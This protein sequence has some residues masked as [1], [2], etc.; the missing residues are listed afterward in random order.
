MVLRCKN[1]KEGEVVI[2]D[3]E[4]YENVIKYNW[5]IIRGKKD[6]Y[7]NRYVTRR[8]YKKNPDGSTYPYPIKTVYLHRHIMKYDGELQIDHIDGNGLNNT[9]KNLR[10]V[11][12]SENAKNRLHGRTALGGRYY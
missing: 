6:G 4:D 12:R 3:D 1:A 8:V 11:T 7:I 2:V 5:T 9:K 10:I